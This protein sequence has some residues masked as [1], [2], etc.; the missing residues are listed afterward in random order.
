M[1]RFSYGLLTLL[2]FAL[3]LSGCDVPKPPPE[4]PTATPGSSNPESPDFQAGFTPV[5]IEPIKGYTPIPSAPGNIFFVRS[6]GLWRISPD[7]SGEKQ[8][9][10]LEVTNPPQPSPDGSMVAFTTA[11]GVYVVPSAG[12]EPRKV[13]SGNIPDGQRLGW[14]PDGKQVGYFT[15]DPETMGKEQA[16]AASV[17]GGDPISIITLTASAVS[18]GPAYE[19]SVRWSPDGLFVAVSGAN[20]PFWLLRWPLSTGREGDIRE[21]PG[22]EPEWSPDGRTIMY[23]ETLSG[24]LLVYGVL[25]AEAT[26][27]R[28]ELR[29]VGTGLGEYAQGPGPRF[30]PASTGSDSDLIAFRSHTQQGE[31]QVAIRRR[32]EGELQPLPPFTNNPAWS[33][34]GDRLVVET[35]SLAAATFGPQWTPNGLSIVR[36]SL[37]AGNPHK[38]FPLVKDARWPAWGK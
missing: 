24:A 4:L 11:D 32:N 29:Y 16:W 30:S 36:L 17:Q 28:N 5:R 3:L 19:K 9:A 12:G 18:R 15:F 23:A 33:P 37:S 27:F 26:P 35:G 20:N 31:P 38:M 7:G 10:S 2:L 34:G 22:G 21:V 25:Q 8:L 13:A 6:S 1:R 14:T